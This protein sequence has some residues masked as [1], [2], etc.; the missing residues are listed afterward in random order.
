MKGLEF[1]I[2]SK[3]RFGETIVEMIDQIVANV[4][5]IFVS[6]APTMLHHKQC[7]TYLCKNFQF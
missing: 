4:I 1:Q 6:P 2:D 7:S 5:P 3:N